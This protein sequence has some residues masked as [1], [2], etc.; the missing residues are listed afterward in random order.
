M[1]HKIKRLMVVPV[2][3]CAVGLAACGGPSDDAQ[4]RQT[5]ANFT[6]A[7]ES[8]NPLNACQYATPASQGNCI[9]LMTGTAKYEP[10][11]KI[12]QEIKGWRRYVRIDRVQIDGDKA[13]MAVPHP[14][15]NDATYP[16][17]K[18]G[19]HWLEDLR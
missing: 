8:E 5:Y 4:I 7:Y 12:R 1:T 14:T 19:G 15:K 18:V 2:A 11:P 9:K 10:Y 6:V 17:V 13:Y 3:L 16:F